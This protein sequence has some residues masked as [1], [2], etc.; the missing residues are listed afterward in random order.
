M[1]DDRD[2]YI[3]RMEAQLEEWNMSMDELQ[4]RVE[5]AEAGSQAAYRER[6][7]KLRR[8]YRVTVERLEAYPER[9]PEEWEE[10]REGMEEARRLLDEGLEEA[11]R[12]LDD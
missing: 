5:R 10:F 11:R 6:V 4:S 2:A 8:D 3:K 1:S 9:D 7:E 12:E